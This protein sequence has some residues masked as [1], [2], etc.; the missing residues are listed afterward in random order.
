MFTVTR[1]TTATLAETTRITGALKSVGIRERQLKRLH[2]QRSVRPESIHNRLTAE[3]RTVCPAQL[4]I[5]ALS[6]QVEK[7][8]NPWSA[9][10]DTTA[11]ELHLT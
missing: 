3:L 8:E 2:Q 4:D 10:V 7:I 6:R 1:D 11:M 9:P 5:T